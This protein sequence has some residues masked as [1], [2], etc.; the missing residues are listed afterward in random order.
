MREADWTKY[1]RTGSADVSDIL[2]VF[3]V[4]CVPVI[5]SLTTSIKS[6]ERVSLVIQVMKQNPLFSI[7]YVSSMKPSYVSCQC[8]TT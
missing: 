4:G 2:T 3:P 6:I 1:S 7:P 8:Q 5:S